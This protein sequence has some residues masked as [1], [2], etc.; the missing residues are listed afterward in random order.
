[1]RERCS[2]PYSLRVNTNKQQGHVIFDVKASAVADMNASFKVSPPNS[3]EKIGEFQRLMKAT[4]LYKD[5]CNNY[6]IRFPKVCS[7]KPTSSI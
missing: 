6:K 2:Q 4:H 1:M 7:N 5:G 3:E